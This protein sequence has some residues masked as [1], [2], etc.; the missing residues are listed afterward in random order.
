MRG[1]F[2]SPPSGRILL[3]VTLLVVGYL[4]FSTGSNVLKSYRLA[5]EESR[6]REQVKVL[7]TERDQLDQIRDY[8]RSDDYVEFMARRVFGLVKPGENLVLIDAQPP[9]SASNKD[10]DQFKKWWQR[11]F[12]PNSSSTWRTP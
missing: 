1:L 5:A 10:R 2:V 7:R 11:L 8:L 9:H 6:L 12:E 4:L 3:V